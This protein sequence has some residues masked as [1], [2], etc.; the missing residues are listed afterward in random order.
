MINDVITVAEAAALL[1]TTPGEL[2]RLAKQGALPSHKGDKVAAAATI[3]AFVRHLRE[4]RANDSEASVALSVSRSYLRDLEKSGAISREADGAFRLE[5]V[6]R[7]YIAWL[8]D[9]NRRGKKTA[10][11][12]RVSDARASEIELRV[13][14]R[15]AELVPMVEA[16]NCIDAVFGPLH[17]ALSGIP[18]QVT[19]D[20]PLRR[21]I[22]NAINAALGKAADAARE[23][24]A[25][26]RSGRD[27]LGESEAPPP[28]AC[29]AK[30]PAP[31]PP[32][33][34]KRL[35]KL[36]ARPRARARAKG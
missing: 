16:M 21:K 24:A 34:K 14:E 33:P 2:H 15:S 12:T 6:Y 28:A 29:K 32:P 10:A 13:A 3:T 20:L 35:R 9:D 19:R 36:R 7:D 26:L 11:A 1:D 8:K 17:G 22:E 30:A 23:A 18:S 4:R 31:P 5:R 27:V 25:A